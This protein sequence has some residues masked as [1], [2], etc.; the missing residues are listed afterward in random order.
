MRISDWSSDVCSSD[1]VVGEIGAELLLVLGIAQTKGEINRV[2]DMKDVVGE[3][4]PV[5][6][7]LI[8]AV[9]DAAQIVEPVEQV[10]GCKDVGARR[11]A[12]AG[13][14]RRADAGDGDER[15]WRRREEI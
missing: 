15:A 6:I 1:L 14:P 12:R 8:I 10:E 5:A 4:R 9:V 7:V 11:A 3:Q 13:D 2:G